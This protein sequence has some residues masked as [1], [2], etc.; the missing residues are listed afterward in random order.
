[1]KFN[2]TLLHM[3]QSPN[4]D[5]ILEDGRYDGISS[6]TGGLGFF[7]VIGYICTCFRNQ[8]TVGYCK[9]KDYS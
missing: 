3:G 4:F 1:M 2:P 9:M 8:W 5:L 7:T 6:I